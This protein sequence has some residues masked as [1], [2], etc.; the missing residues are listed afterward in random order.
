MLERRIRGRVSPLLSNFLGLLNQK[1]RLGLLPQIAAAYDDLLDEQ[2][3][4]VE[5]DV[6]VAQPLDASN[7]SRSASRSSQAL[8][9]DAVVHQYVDESIIGGLVLRVQDQLI[10]ASVRYQLQAIRS[11]LLSAGRRS[12]RIEL[13]TVS[14]R[15]QLRTQPVAA[16]NG[17]S[18][19]TANCNSKRTRRRHGNQRRGNHQRPEA[20]NRRLRA[21]AARSA[22]SA[23]SSKSATA[24]PASTACATPWP[25]NCS[26]SQN[27]VMGQVFNLEEDSIGAVIFGNYLEIKEGDTVKSTGRLLEVPVGEAVIGRVVNPLGQPLD[28]GAA[29]PHAPRR[30]RW[31]SS[32]RA[33]PSASR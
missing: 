5:V 16:A 31:T 7:W 24:S 3:G 13:A 20:G 4:K 30:A 25:A 17:Q 1:G 12:R 11:K 26:S 32:P 8:G 21:A 23:R 27:G 33:S 10:D 9:K 19:L 22:R 28:G 6:T 2:F 29:D 18:T 15:G 14:G